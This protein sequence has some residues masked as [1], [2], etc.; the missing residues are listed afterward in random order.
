MASTDLGRWEP[1]PVAA[2]L[3]LFGGAP[4][5]WWLSGG[6]ALELHADR[7][8]NN[9]WCRPEPGGPWCLDVTVGEGT[10]D[11]G[12]YRRDHDVRAPWSEA[13]LVTPDGI[14]YLAPELQLLFKSTRP[15]P[16]DD[17]DARQ[18]IP[19]LEGDRRARL[20]RLLPQRHPWQGQF[21]PPRGG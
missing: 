14:P 6:R 12:I 20:S 19:I 3:G 11:E 18:V 2:V 5:R 10:D 7:H 13:V 1:L 8:E 15:R 17:V 4:F 16:K 21:T 9:L